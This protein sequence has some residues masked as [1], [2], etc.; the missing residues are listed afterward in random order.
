MHFNMIMTTHGFWVGV[1]CCPLS[2]ALRCG[3]LWNI[4]FS[5]WPSLDHF[6]LLIL[7]TFE[8]YFKDYVSGASLGYDVVKFIRPGGVFARKNHDTSL[9]WKI[10]LFGASERVTRSTAPRARPRGYLKSEAS[11]CSLAAMLTITD[12][13]WLPHQTSSSADLTLVPY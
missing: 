8:P 2:W 6:W 11:N 9:K 5:S 12:V 10:P 13:L 1:H 7:K 3:T 4:M